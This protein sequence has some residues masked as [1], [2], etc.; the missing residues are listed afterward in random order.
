MGLKPIKTKEQY[1]AYLKIIDSLVDCAEDSPEEETLE[2]VSILVEDYESKHYAIEAPDPIEAIKI[3]IEEE[4]IKRKDL[5][6][7][8]GSSSR[9][10]EVLNRK[11]PLT[12]EMMRKLHEGLGIS[13]KT[14]LG[15]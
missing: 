11:R 13:A 7:Y 10:S 6:Q 14:L 5:A 2:L 15:V 3:K 8:F 9:V 12:L 4:G 1:Q